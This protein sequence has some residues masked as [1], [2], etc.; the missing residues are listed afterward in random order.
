MPGI[1]YLVDEPLQRSELVADHLKRVFE[2]LA[3]LCVTDTEQLANRDAHSLDQRQRQG[4]NATQILEQLLEPV[5]L[6]Q[7][8]VGFD[9]KIPDT[10]DKCRESSGAFSNCSNKIE[11]NAD[12]ILDYRPADVYGSE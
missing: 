6:D 8:L 12:K 3:V 5:A 11:D 2:T 9:Q 10:S 4:N 7:R 1:N